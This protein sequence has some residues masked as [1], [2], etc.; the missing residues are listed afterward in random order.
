MSEIVKTE[1]IVLKTM[2]YRETSKIMTYFTLEHGKISAILKGAR[3]SKTMYGTALEPMSYVAI[4]LYE[5]KGRDLQTVTQC[6]LVRSYRNLFED[7]D[8]MGIGMVI[9]ELVRHVAHEQEKNTKLFHLLEKT[10]STLNDATRNAINLFYY[11]EIRLAQILGFSPSFRYC[12]SCK[13]DVLALKIE[14]KK[15]TFDMEN[16]SPLCGKCLSSSGQKVLLSQG[17]LESLDFLANEDE[18]GRVIEHYLE[19]GTELEIESFLFAYLR[20]HVS[21]MKVLKS[22]RLFAN[23]QRVESAG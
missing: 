11:F 4:I 9:I 7:F 16:G 12:A 21:G 20:R 1:A 23:L 3:S 8:K 15:I 18:E 17:A 22:R 2:K 5:K 19:I 6:E 14:K 10:L 13:V